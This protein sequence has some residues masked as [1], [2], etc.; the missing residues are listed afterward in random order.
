MRKFT[1]LL[2]VIFAAANLFAEQYKSKTW[3]SDLGNGRYRN[4]I[5]YADYPELDVC[6]AG[7]DYYMVSASRHR[8]ARKASSQVIR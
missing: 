8:C 3:I 7:D 1:F 6:K 5:L 2:A 4:P